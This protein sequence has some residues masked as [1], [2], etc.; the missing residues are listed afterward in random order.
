MQ[1]LSVKSVNSIWGY[2]ELSVLIPGNADSV[3][4]RPCIVSGLSTHIKTS[5]SKV[6]GT[7]LHRRVTKGHVDRWIWPGII[8]LSHRCQVT[9]TDEMELETNN[10]LHGV[11]LFWS[12]FIYTA[13]GCFGKLYSK[14]IALGE[15]KILTR[16]KRQRFQ[17]MKELS[18]CTLLTFSYPSK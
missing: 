9:L 12:T 4:A 11:N 13:L 15:V 16:C 18:R 3:G 8:L 6:N 17:H 14:K 10:L 5:G 7:E 1:D 2:L